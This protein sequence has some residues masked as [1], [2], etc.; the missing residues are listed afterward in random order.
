M[1]HFDYRCECNRLGTYATAKYSSCS[2]C[3]PGT[4]SNQINQTSC[5]ECTPGTFQPYSNATTCYNCSADFYQPLSS[6]TECIPCP[7][8]GSSFCRQNSSTAGEG[9]PVVVLPC[10]SNRCQN[11]GT[12]VNLASDGGFLFRCDC[13]PDIGVSDEL[14]RDPQSF[15][16]SGVQ[17]TSGQMLAISVITIGVASISTAAAAPSVLMPAIISSIS[18]SLLF[19]S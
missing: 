2:A 14:C 8:T 5:L 16:P 12:C 4:Y 19:L 17:E 3:S 10:T 15:T 7:M 6:Q 18:L 9:V 13:A 11:G 1:N